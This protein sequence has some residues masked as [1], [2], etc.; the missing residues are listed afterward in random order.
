M[1]VLTELSTS[2]PPPTP[3]AISARPTSC[4][5]P[6]RSASASRATAA[7]TSGGSKSIS[8]SARTPPAAAPITRP[9]TGNAHRDEIKSGGLSSGKRY[10]PIGMRL[11][12]RKA[13][14][15]SPTSDCRRACQ[16]LRSFLVADPA[17]QRHAG[18]LRAARTSMAATAAPLA[19]PSEDQGRAVCGVPRQAAW[20]G[21]GDRCEIMQGSRT[22]S[23][24][25][26]VALRRRRR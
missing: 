19:S 13:A 21:S 5:P 17:R 2:R 7:L 6:D 3:S 26:T 20:P 9:T 24:L 1:H 16:I 14:A 10:Q 25:P 15:Q 22:S 23:L 8:L 4:I 18:K 12:N 11:S